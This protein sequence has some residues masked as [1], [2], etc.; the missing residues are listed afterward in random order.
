MPAEG[1][2]KA[3]KFAPTVRGC[4][5]RCSQNRRSWTLFDEIDLLPGYAMG[6]WGPRH[7]HAL[8]KSMNTRNL[9]GICFWLGQSSQNWPD[10]AS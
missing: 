5:A 3:R 10:C 4:P 1:P 8:R 7:K 6:N 2:A 9:G